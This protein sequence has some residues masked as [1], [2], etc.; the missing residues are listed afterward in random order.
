MAEKNGSKENAKTKETTKTVGKKIA[1]GSTKKV[2]QKRSSSAASKTTTAKKTTTG[3]TTTTKKTSTKA[4]S[5]TNTT[6]KTE[7]KTKT[8][9]SKKSTATKNIKPAIA[10]MPT[11]DLEKQSVTTVKEEAKVGTKKVGTKT[12][13][14]AVA[15]TATKTT[16]KTAAKSSAK[17]GAKTTSAKSGAKTTAKKADTKKKDVKVVEKEEL[18]KKDEEIISKVDNKEEK[19][20]K[21]TAKKVENKKTTD[22]KLQARSSSEIEEAVEKEIKGRK[23]LPEVEFNKINTR[24]FQNICL[25]VLTMLYLHFVV[26]GFVNIENSVFVTDIKVFSIALLIVAI[27]IFEYAYKKDSG[28]HAI[29]GIEVLMLALTTMAFIYTNLI[30][31]DRFIY[32]VA[33]VTYLF[34]IYYVAKSIIIY[35]KMKKEYFVN[36]MKEIIKK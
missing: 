15:K 33:L 4:S 20:K 30:W 25:A 26:L 18:D 23:K 7:S 27:A 3:K 6:P 16:K 13:S 24:I 8:T 11:E 34:A 31:A 5:K 32:V 10:E 36:E 17:S 19:A 14:K 9:T 29:H 35:N 21:E 1:T 22:T 12:A 2:V 28:R